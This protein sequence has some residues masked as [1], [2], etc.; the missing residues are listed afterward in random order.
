[1]ILSAP[2]SKQTQLLLLKPKSWSYT[3]K[4]S[5]FALQ[6]QEYSV[7]ENNIFECSA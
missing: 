2:R 5:H 1:M 4:Q 7:R 6:N 3:R